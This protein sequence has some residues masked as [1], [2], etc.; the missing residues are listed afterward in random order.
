[1]RRRWAHGF[2]G[3]MVAVA[4][5]IGV[6]AAG[7]TV[8]A[9]ST[10]EFCQPTRADEVSPGPGGQTGVVLAVNK[11]RAEAGRSVFARL[12]NFSSKTAGY[13]REF[14]IERYGAGKW[15]VDESGP[16]GPWPKSRGILSPG[17]AGG[18]Y[19]FNVPPELSSGRY[20]FST[21]IS[22]RTGSSSALVRR[23]GEFTVP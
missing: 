5:A 7:G 11:K 3:G 18:C 6:M 12:L 22:F 16:A 21:Q 17:S 10:P 19:R 15:T 2:A 4:A 20:R 1:M 8:V 13:V 9:S 23:V 14:R